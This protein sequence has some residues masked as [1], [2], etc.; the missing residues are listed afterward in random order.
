MDITSFVLGY[1][2]GKAEG[3]G[4]LTEDVCHV[5]FMNGDT[6]LY[7][8]PVFVGDDCTDIVK[9]GTIGTPSKVSTPQYS[10]TYTG[11]SL[12]NGGEAS[13]SALAAVSGD[14]TVYAAY[15]SV[16]RCYTITYL[17]EDGSVMKTESLAYG[18]MPS[19]TPAKEG[20]S[21]VGWEPALAT[22]TQNATYTAKWLEKVTFAGSSWAE[23][24]RISEAGEAANYFKVGDTRE[25][26]FDF[27]GTTETV[28]V[29]IVGMNHDDLADGS[30][31]AGLSVVLAQGLSRASCDVTENTN[32]GSYYIWKNSAS[33]ASLNSGAIYQAIPAELRAVLK[34]VTKTSNSGKGNA[35]DGSGY[36]QNVLYNTSD[37]VW[38]LSSTEVGFDGV[39]AA[40]SS[41]I[42]QGKQYEYYT[43]DARRVVELRV[44][45]G[46]GTQ[47]HWPLR[48][49]NAQNTMSSIFVNSSGQNSTG[50]L[51]EDSTK[52][53]EP[54]VFGF[55]I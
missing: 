36:A 17:D 53:G 41:A 32:Y 33:R 23:I 19:Y 30:G 10:Y 50:L 21:F 9:K 45:D 15:K 1:K 44:K 42:N 29:R 52:S 47:M 39:V 38:L 43:S 13:I 4:A 12:T 7:E 40:S 46:T 31:K 48:S 6:V 5:T 54:N 20:F 51:G 22:V 35:Y 2:K 28:L 49:M 18:T 24:A 16:L 14:R 55:C 34:T 27:S 11:W 3:G 25:V 37:T 8:K 26:T